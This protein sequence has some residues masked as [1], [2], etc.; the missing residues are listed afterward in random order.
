M[1][2]A[3]DGRAR[4]VDDD[5]A[6][7][8][9]PSATVASRTPGHA[10]RGGRFA[11]IVDA[12]GL[13]PLVEIAR[14]CPNPDVRLYAKLEFMNPTGSVKDRVARA[15]IDDLERDGRLGPDSIILE[16]TS[17]NTGISLAMIARRKGYRVT[18]VVPDNVT[19]ERRQLLTLFGAEIIES[20]GELGSNGAVALAKELVASDPRYVM[21]YQYGNPENPRAH[22]E[23]TAEEIIADCP[24]VDVFVAGLGHRRDARRR[25]AAAATPQPGR[26]RLRGRAATRRAGAGPP[27]ARRGLHPRDLRPERDRREA[28][29][30]ERGVDPALRDLT[31]REGIFAG[32]SSGAVV[33]AAQQVAREMDERHDRRAPRRRRLEVPV[34]GHL[35]ARPRSR[36][37]PSREPQPLVSRRT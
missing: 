4:D 8:S 24:E 12:I 33:V 21:P 32:V 14:L 28:A 27:V 18:V 25:R 19:V 36:R 3:A 37:R 31:T 29:R 30:L 34:R 17:G 15:L 35:D 2:G 6:G 20:P 22:E 9:R 5:P 13:T 10:R 26:P 16:P 23:T 1:A 11:S 7:R